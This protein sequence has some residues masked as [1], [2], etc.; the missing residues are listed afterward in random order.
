M[1]KFRKRPIEV[2]AVQYLGDNLG[3]LMRLLVPHAKPNPFML[4]RGGLLTVNSKGHYIP[5]YKTDW[6]IKDIEGDLYPCTDNV[7]K[8]TYDKLVTE[9]TTT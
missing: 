2:D 1:T 9:E 7:F 4:D 8:K 6:V 5:V 3:E